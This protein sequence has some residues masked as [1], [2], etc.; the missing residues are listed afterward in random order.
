[1]AHVRLLSEVFA[2]EE[3]VLHRLTQVDCEFDGL[4]LNVIR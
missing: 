2:N 1:M 4:W 3:V